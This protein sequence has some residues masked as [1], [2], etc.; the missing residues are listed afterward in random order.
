MVALKQNDLHFYDGSMY[1]VTKIR[2]N[3]IENKN[4][5]NGRHAINANGWCF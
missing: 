5:Q 2:C 3:R 1:I 4:V